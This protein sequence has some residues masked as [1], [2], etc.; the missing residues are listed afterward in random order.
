M[1][2]DRR[3]YTIVL[4]AIAVILVMALVINGVAL[5]KSDKPDK[6]KATNGQVVVPHHNKPDK[7]MRVNCHSR[8][9]REAGINCGENDQPAATTPASSTS[10]TTTQP[11]IYPAN[12]RSFTGGGGSGSH[13][14]YMM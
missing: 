3:H 9:A 11:A 7:E 14:R 10:G 13:V 8:H 12:I 6:D 4:V 1:Y 5:A 2:T